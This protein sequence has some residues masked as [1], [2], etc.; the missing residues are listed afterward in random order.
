MTILFRR[1]EITTDRHPQRYVDRSC[2]HGVNVI[3]L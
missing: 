1:Q 3:P 2:R